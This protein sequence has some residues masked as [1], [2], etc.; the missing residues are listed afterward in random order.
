MSSS[1]SAPRRPSETELLDWMKIKPRT[2]GWDAWFSY[3]QSVCN[4][5]LWRDYIERTGEHPFS[6]VFTGKVEVAEAVLWENL[7]D[8]RLGAPQI[9]F[10]NSRPSSARVTLHARALSG[11]QLTVE[12]TAGSRKY[13]SRIA[14]YSPLQGPRLVADAF[15]DD[16]EGAANAAR[17]VRMDLTLAEK[18]QFSFPGPRMQQIKG[19]DFFR[20]Q[21]EALPAAARYCRLHTLGEWDGALVPEIVRPRPIP[22]LDAD[23]TPTGD[24]ALVVMVA[25]TDSEVGDL[26]DVDGD[27]KY[28]IPEGSHASLWIGAHCLMK[29]VVA[30]SL[31]GVGGDVELSY[32]DANDPKVITVTQGTLA[33]IAV[34]ARP[35]QFI[36]LNYSVK[37]PLAGNA[38]ASAALAISRA[39]TGLAVNWKTSTF[40]NV[41]APLLES[42]GPDGT[43][44]LDV[45]WRIRST[46]AFAR[47]ADG[48]LGLEPVGQGVHWVK[49][50]YRQNGELDAVHYQHFPA[51]E[52]AIG[53]AVSEQVDIV[54]A[55]MLGG[56]ELGEI[57]RLRYEGLQCPGGGGM[58][59]DTVHLPNDLALFGTLGARAQ[60]FLLT[61][62]YDRILAGT[63][64]QFA[65]DPLPEELEWAVETVDGFEGDAG[66]IDGTGLYTA[67]AVADISGRFVLVKVTATSPKHHSEALLAVLTENLAL[68][69]V[70]FVSATPGSTMRMSAGSLQGGALEWDLTSATGA[71]L[72]VPDPEDGS[73]FDPDD[74]IYVRGSG[75]TD[76]YFSVDEMSVSNSA[77]DT[78]TTQVLVVE[79]V[80]AGA[81]VVREGGGLPAGQVQLDYDIGMPDPAA[82]AQW[83]VQIGGGSITQTGLYTVDPQA[84]E[85]FAVI[86]AE[87]DNVARHWANFLI[88]PI[89][90]VDLGELRSA[91]R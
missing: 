64:L 41:E 50:V 86:T 3:D 61:P 43:T 46:Y 25:T 70:V 76:A 49:P 54:V 9:S 12:T 73:V 19:G 63:T 33:E 30:S 82:D 89:P 24:G 42:E 48:N 44:A 79:K 14:E 37:V 52:K 8:V 78:R 88:L 60:T 11:T 18:H 55:R 71:T 34:K 21:I 74:R 57:D 13:I 35:V 47:Q 38:A 68:N 6:T 40:A 2:L 7:Y 65:A 62:A 56:S 75:S 58:A 51:V 4:Q 28:P 17:Q 85:P 72:E 31:L 45:A 32:D 10:E 20:E 90:L 26:P 23:G 59:L 91:L 67:P 36:A 69:P 87:V 53:E 5:S 84:K 83:K 66:S 1:T 15:I 39:D 27:W 77:G 29:K 22:L 80:A 81:I 16:N